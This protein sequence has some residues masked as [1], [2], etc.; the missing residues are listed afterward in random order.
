[1]LYALLWTSKHERLALIV[2]ASVKSLEFC[3]KSCIHFFGGLVRPSVAWKLSW[4]SVL[5]PCVS[6]IKHLSWLVSSSD[7]PWIQKRCIARQR[8]DIRWIIPL[9][10]IDDIRPVI[11]T[12]WCL[13]L[14]TLICEVHSSRFTRIYIKPLELYYS[15][16]GKVSSKNVLRVVRSLM[17]WWS[18]RCTKL[19]YAWRTWSLVQ[20]PESQA[21]WANDPEYYCPSL[22]SFP[23]IHPMLEGHRRTTSPWKMCQFWSLL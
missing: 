23:Q 11:H 1:M 19:R 9:P 10:V 21:V 2:I 16:P 14:V 12:H 7:S 22:P 4:Q 6:F 8:S 20:R 3:R 18:W 15:N 13:R 17:I 5:M